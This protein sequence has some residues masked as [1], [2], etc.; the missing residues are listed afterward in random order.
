MSDDERRR[1]A[2]RRVQ[3]K[4]SAQ[5]HLATYLGVNV[6][7]VVIWAISG[8][9]YFWPVFPIVFW[10][11]GLA[12]HAWAVYGAKPITEAEI[13]REMERGGDLI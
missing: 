4:K 13:Q 3:A 2:I 5:Y 1:A 10:G 12:A 11:F 9:G 8:M 7:L 6:L